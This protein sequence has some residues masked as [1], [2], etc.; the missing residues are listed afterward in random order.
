MTRA[1]GVVGIEYVFAPNST[2]HKGYRGREA[3]MTKL[4]VIA[5]IFFLL[6]KHSIND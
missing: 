4:T 2:E 3:N 1:Y 6:S 5:L